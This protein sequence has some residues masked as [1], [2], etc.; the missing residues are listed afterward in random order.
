MN[1]D[2]LF[3]RITSTAHR[4]R[5][6]ASAASLILLA[7]CFPGC[8]T[9]QADGPS[10]GPRA[11]HDL[12]AESAPQGSSLRQDAATPT[13]EDADRLAK[14]LQNPVADLISLPFQYDSFQ[15]WG[16][17]RSPRNVLSIKPVIPIH[18]TDDWNI[19]TRTTV[20]LISQPGQQG[21]G[22]TY[23]IGDTNLQFLFSPIEPAESGITWGAGPAFQLPTHTDDDLGNN[24]W[25]AGPAAAALTMHGPWVYGAVGQHLWASRGS[26]KS[27]NIS[28]SLIQPFVNYNFGQGSYLVS[29]PDITADWNAENGGDVWNLPVGGG[30]GHVFFAGE[31][32][33]DVQ[34]QAFYN[35][36]HPKDAGNWSARLR[37]TLLYPQAPSGDIH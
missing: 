23:G 24:K 37:V 15:N 6:P 1:V 5:R 8:T 9:I 32:P 19:I 33:I 31:R 25:A 11:W 34:F 13:E 21:D 7:C 4:V 12:A 28:Q 30:A 35:V 20:P 16:E 26:D 17:D 3:Q 36:H 18:V 22:R 2:L 14:Q 29:S 27:T 10:T